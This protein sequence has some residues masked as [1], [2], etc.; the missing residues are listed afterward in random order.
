MSQKNKTPESL[1][2]VKKH[3]FRNVWIWFSQK[4]RWVKII[5]SIAGVV[6]LLIAA[7]LNLFGEPF[8]CYSKLVLPIYISSVD[9]KTPVISLLLSYEIEDNFGRRTGKLGDTCYDGD[10]LYISFKSGL[11][12]WVSV[13]GVDSK[14]IYPVFKEKLDPSFIENEQNY[15]LDFSLDKT[16]GNE[17]YYAIAASEPFSFQEE[18][19]PHLMNVF[20]AGNSKGPAFSEY[21]LELP[22]KFTQEFIY[23]KHLSRQ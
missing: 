12:C 4:P 13:F 11:P 17:V 16:A 19:E 5:F 8:Y 3:L 2:D 6:L 10:H 21:Q 23:F 22:E 9:P 18:I 7:R 14:A 20:P 1:E 15:T